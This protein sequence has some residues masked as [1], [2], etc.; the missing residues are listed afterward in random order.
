M[1][2]PSFPFSRGTLIKSVLFALAVT[3]LIFNALNGERGLYAYLQQI[4]SREL[5]QTELEKVR[6]ERE[7]LENKVQHMRDGSLDLDLLD[8]QMRRTLGVMGG[9]EVMVI[10]EPAE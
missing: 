10:T 4:H 9:D 7:T 5:T 1:Q 3:Y 8:E 2:I 6:S